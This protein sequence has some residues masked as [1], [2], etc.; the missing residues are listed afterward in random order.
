LHFANFF[1]AKKFTEKRRVV[2]NNI[3]NLESTKAVGIAP[4]ETRSQVAA[5]SGLG[6]SSRFQRKRTGM[7]KRK[8]AC[9]TLILILLTV[10]L[11]AC[12]YS[13]PQSTPPPPTG[14]ARFALVSNLTDNTISTFAIDSQMHGLRCLQGARTPELLP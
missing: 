2:R 8:F 7:S 1:V 6:S 11:V 10:L 3:G 13:A 5:A 9:S 4:G 14:T 12:G